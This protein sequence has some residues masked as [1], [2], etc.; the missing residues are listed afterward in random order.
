MTTAFDRW[1]A[2]R[3]FLGKHP[4]LQAIAAATIVCAATGYQVFGGSERRQG[5]DM[6]SQERP[7]AILQ[8]EQRSREA[9]LEAKKK[10]K[11]ESSQQ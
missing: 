3:A 2:Q 11:Q 4:A 1:I 6:F 5:H 7:E 10:K 9:Y 8:A